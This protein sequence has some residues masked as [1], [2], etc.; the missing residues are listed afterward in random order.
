MIT[1]GKDGQSFFINSF[2]FF[3][4][5]CKFVGGFF[6]YTHVLVLLPNFLAL[7]KYLELDTT[8]MTDDIAIRLKWSYLSYRTYLLTYELFNK[9]INEYDVGNIIKLIYSQ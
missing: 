9:E 3:D 8:S 7:L 2:S 1:A 6:L 5:V 4:C